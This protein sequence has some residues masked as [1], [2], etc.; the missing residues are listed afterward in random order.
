[1]RNQRLR[2]TSPPSQGSLLRATPP[3][4]C[5]LDFMSLILTFVVVFFFFAMIVSSRLDP[6]NVIPCVPAVPPRSAGPSIDLAGLVGGKRR[7]G[8]PAR[9]TSALS[10]H[11]AAGPRRLGD[12]GSRTEAPVA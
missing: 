6:L 9:R 2:L 10:G 11:F 1:M 8:I 12:D 5:F 7:A 3:L 4:T